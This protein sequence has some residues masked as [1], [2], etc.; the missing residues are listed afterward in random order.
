MDLRMSRARAFLEA[1]DLPI[2][3]IALACGFDD[4]SYFAR[5]FRAAHGV[6]AATWRLSAR[7]DDPR[8]TSVAVTFDDYQAAMDVAEQTA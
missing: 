8:F 5:V 4:P 2:A 1:T 7:P 3:S 6:T